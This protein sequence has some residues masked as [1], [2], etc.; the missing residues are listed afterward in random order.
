MNGVDIAI[1]A[2]LI[3]SV[4]VGLWRGFVRELMALAVWFAALWLAWNGAAPGAGLL[5]SW[6][7]TPSLRVIVA[8]AAIFGL[9]LA[10]GALATW[11]IGRVVHKTGLDGTD[12]LVGMVFGLARGVVLVVIAVLL[13]RLTP[14][15]ADP[16]WRESRLLPGFEK[17]AARAADWLPATLRDYLA[18]DN[19]APAAGGERA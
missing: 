5:T 12:R 11:L 1:I 14:F 9:A 10:V 17:A 16:W 6:V 19:A 8:F 15:T 2:V 4:I 3:L 7:S 13:A 18:A